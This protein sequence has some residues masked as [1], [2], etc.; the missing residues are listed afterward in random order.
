[1]RLWRLKIAKMSDVVTPDNH[2]DVYLVTV[3]TQMGITKCSQEARRCFVLVVMHEC[4]IVLRYR[5]SQKIGHRIPSLVSHLLSS[6]TS[7]P[8]SKR[9][10]WA[11]NATAITA[12][13]RQLSSFQQ[14]P[15]HH[16]H[17]I[18]IT[19]DV[20]LSP[21]YSP[22]SENH[23]SLARNT[24]IVNMPSVRAYR[25]THLPSLRPYTNSFSNSTR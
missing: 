16:R 6:I 21:T 15:I 2:V 24:K 12:Q 1:M 11:L 20:K 18:N 13:A 25:T 4:V 9:R 22:A 7:Q 14:L 17:I 10:G 8:T 3:H 5:F 19:K 23:E